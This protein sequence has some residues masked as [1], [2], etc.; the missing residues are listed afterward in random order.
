[1]S[2]AGDISG[3]MALADWLGSNQVPV[4][5]DH[6][7]VR[8]KTCLNCPHNIEPNWW[9]RVKEVAAHWIQRELEEKH[10]LQLNTRL[11]DQLHMCAVCGCC[12]KLKIWVPPERIRQAAPPEKLHQTPFYCF[13]R[14]E[15][16]HA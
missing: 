12:L 2:V 13:M 4:T 14:K 8:A 7:E 11:D 5:L 16:L 10:K 15:L 9:D 1:M 6:A 3:A